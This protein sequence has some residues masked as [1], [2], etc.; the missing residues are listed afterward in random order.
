MGDLLRYAHDGYL[1]DGA[2]IAVELA[3][4]SMAV[5]LVLG[6][7]LALLRLSR[8]LPLRL[9][10]GLYVWFMRGT[11][12]LLQ[13]VVLY[14]VL[15]TVGPTLS[16]FQTA[17]LGFSLNQAAFNAEIIR[18][19][20]LSVDRRQIVAAQSIGMAPAATVRRVVL[21]QAMPAIVPALGNE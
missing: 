9:L 17:L 7:L 12:L 10:S 11:P 13:L 15:P 14:D 3:M 1:L 18:G 19:G 21:P 8:V 20:I 4:I 2:L 6:M 16:P 5:S